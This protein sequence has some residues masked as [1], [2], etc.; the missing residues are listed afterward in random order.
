MDIVKICKQYSLL[1]PERLLN[2]MEST[3][4]VDA[5]KIPGD[6]VEVGVFKGGSMLSMMLTCTEPRD[7]YLYDTFEGMTPPIDADV[8]LTGKKASDI[9]EQVMCYAGIEEVKRNIFAH[10]EVPSER[11]HFVKGDILKNEVFPQKI[12]ILRIDTDWYESTKYELEHFYPLVSEGG[13]II[14]D[15]YGHWKGCRK[16]VDEFIA[17]KDITLI[18]IDYTGVYFVKNLR[19]DL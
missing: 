7:F 4:L 18:P 19:R 3:R 15:D 16:A 5:G 11:I 13:V 12:A 14:I 17:G 2:N 6:I 1:S 9:L 8:D 10:T